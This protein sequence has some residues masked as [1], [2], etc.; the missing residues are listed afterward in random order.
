[1]SGTTI[2][3]NL[4]SSSRASA[5]GRS[6]ASSSGSIE[7]VRQPGGSASASSDAL[8]LDKESRRIAAA[9]H[10]HEEDIKT[11]LPEAVKLDR[12]EDDWQVPYV[13]AFINNFNLRGRIARLETQQDFERALQEPVAERPDDILE[14]IM[15]CF[16]GNLKPGGGRSLT[17]RPENIQA[18]VSNYI[19]DKLTNTSEW[20]V[21]D[22]GWPINEEDRGMCCIDDPYRTELGRLR[23]AGESMSTRGEKNPLKRIE[24]LG[25]GLFELDWKERV[26]ILRQLVDWQLTHSEPI[27]NMINREF[28]AKALDSRAKKPSTETADKDSIVT[29]ELGLNRDRARVWA[30]DDSWRLYKSGNPFKRPC[31]LTLLA[32]TRDEYETVLSEIE[33]FGAQPTANSKGKET[34]AQK[35][36]AVSIRNEK[37]L[38]EKLRERIEGIEK[39]ETRIQRAKKRVAQALELQ[40]R[41][42][43]R[44]TRTRRQTTKVDYVYGDYDFDDDDGPSKRS[45]TSRGATS[46]T[47]AYADGVDA[48]GRAIIPGERRSARTSGRNAAAQP[49][50]EESEP[51]SKAESAD[52]D[53]VISA[54]SPERNGDAMTGIDSPPNGRP[55]NGDGSPTNGHSRA[56]SAG[57]SLEVI[58]V[59]AE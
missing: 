1:M 11:H 2:K 31:P 20:T 34:A 58:E 16:L 10:R 14:S 15:I 50:Y 48:R 56:G 8:P 59:D 54:A 4:G 23:Y 52:G 33:A 46:A 39:E 55:T 38:G 18:Q 44:S 45:R 42:E 7:E 40:Q 49:A 47:D 51:A 32:T 36:L 24:K 30:F 29:R 5:E 37:A 43:L 27:R 12:L 57:E 3:I 28:P 26:R 41:A 13:W 35:K 21:W 25:G 19:S 17:C 9:R 22:R 6:R 53:Q